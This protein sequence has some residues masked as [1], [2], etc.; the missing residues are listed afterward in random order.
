M[1][2]YVSTPSTEKYGHR[3][4]D[5]QMKI[6]LYIILPISLN[7]KYRKSDLRSRFSNET[8]AVW[9]PHVT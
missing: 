3:E 1:L 4:K 8:S 9:K 7:V 2:H 5:G 6:Q